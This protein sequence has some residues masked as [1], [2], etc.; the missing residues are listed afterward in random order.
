LFE[1]GLSAGVVSLE[2][3]NGESFEPVMSALQFADIIDSSC[4]EGWPANLDE[5]CESA[6]ANNRDYLAESMRVDI[7]QLNATNRTR[8]PRKIEA[9]IR[10]IARGISGGIAATTIEQNV[11]GE[12]TSIS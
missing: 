12:Q 8:D 1:L 6:M 9:L 11:R 2:F 7:A 3:L 10:S 5:G 4:S